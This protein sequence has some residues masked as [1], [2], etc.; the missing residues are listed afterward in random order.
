[1]TLNSAGNRLLEKFTQCDSS[2][3]FESNIVRALRYERPVIH[4]SCFLYQRDSGKILS[5]ISLGMIKFE[6]ELHS[7][8]I[9]DH[10]RSFNLHKKFVVALFKHN[11]STLDNYIK[12][13]ILIWV[14]NYNPWT[15]QCVHKSTVRK[16]SNR[17]IQCVHI[18][19]E[20]SNDMFN[21]SIYATYAIK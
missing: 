9:Y 10:V 19:S 4:T 15:Q 21:R 16:R 8:Q 13:M 14:I 1:M 2:M 12:L 11:T 6:Q 20:I 5:S 7:S 17:K 3:L 18:Q